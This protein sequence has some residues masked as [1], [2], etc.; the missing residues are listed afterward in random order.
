MSNNDA[1]FRSIEEVD[2]YYAAVPPP[3]SILDEL[4]ACGN[5]PIAKMNVMVGSLAAYISEHSRPFDWMQ[6]AGKHAADV[7]VT[8][9]RDGEGWR[10][11]RCGKGALQ[12]SLILDDRGG[13]VGLLDSWVSVEKIPNLIAALEAARDAIESATS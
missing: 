3:P 12:V 4:N 9:T 13:H 2:A 1:S 7:K 6:E 11:V 10:R 8:K 5:D